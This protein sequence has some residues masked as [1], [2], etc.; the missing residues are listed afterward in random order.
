MTIS[1]TT[2]I[3]AGAGIS[4][5]T[6][7]GSAGISDNGGGAYEGPLDLVPGAVVAYS[8][9]AMAAAWTNPVIRLREDD[10]DAEQDFSPVNNAVSVA[11]VETFLNGNNGFWVNHYDQSGNGGDSKQTTTAKQPQWTANAINSKPGFVFGGSQY[12]ITD[13]PVTWENGT[14]TIFFVCSLSDLDLNILCGFSSATDY[15]D[16]RANRDAEIGFDAYQDFTGNECGVRGTPATPLGADFHIIECA[17]TFGNN[18]IL[19]DGV[20]ITPT[21]SNDSGGTLGTIADRFC[22]GTDNFESL[23][24][25]GTWVELIGYDS[26]LSAPNRLAIRQNIAAYYGITLP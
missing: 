8:Q 1:P 3:S 17:C 11:A 20:P 2:G 24:L 19:V 14:Y 21:G 6:G 18:V 15:L 5:A 13:D 7:I 10:G 4:P 9:R 22:V 16:F 23:I 12:G 25:N 26:I